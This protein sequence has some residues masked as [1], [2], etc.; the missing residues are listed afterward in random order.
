MQLISNFNKGFTSLLCVIG[1]NGKCAWVIPLN[2][3]KGITV[4]NAFPKS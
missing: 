4:T 1:I 2:D 3:K